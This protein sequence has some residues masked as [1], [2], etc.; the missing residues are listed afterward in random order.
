MQV[1][2]GVSLAAMLCLFAGSAMA[3]SAVLNSDMTAF[4]GPGDNYRPVLHLVAGQRIDILECDFKQWCQV[5]HDGTKGWVHAKLA[6]PTPGAGGGKPG[7]SGTP[8][9][10]MPGSTGDSASGGGGAG[11]TKGGGSGGGSR[12]TFSKVGGIEFVGDPGK[13]GGGRPDGSLA[14]FPGS[15]GDGRSSAMATES[16]TPA[17]AASEAAKAPP[18][19][20]C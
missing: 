20:S 18:C 16:A 6:Q 1:S 10:D 8:G 2:L 15:S 17:S 19:R 12:P 13:V 9:A 4:D 14:D 5:E 7:Q 11:G 3:G